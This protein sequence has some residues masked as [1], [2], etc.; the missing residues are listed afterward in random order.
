VSRFEYLSVLISIVIALGL[1]EVLSA[2][3]RLLRHRARVRPYWVHGLWSL[4]IVLLM[5]EFWWGFWQFR[6]VAAWSF[7][8]FLAVLA[9]SLV[10]VLAALVITPG[11]FAEGDLDLRT[12]FYENARLFFVL[13]AVLLVQLAVVDAV[14]GGQPFVHVENAFRAAGLGVLVWAALSRSERV[15]GALALAALGL[16]LVFTAFTFA[17]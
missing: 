6:V 14:V 11:D 13:G 16:L 10:M 12:H 5:V 3:G 8:G 7:A 4:L 1:S 9:E 17:S 15:H 2:W